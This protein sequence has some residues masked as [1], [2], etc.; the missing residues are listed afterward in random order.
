MVVVLGLDT[1]DASNVD[2]S[3]LGHSYFAEKHTVISD[4]FY[5]IGEGKAP[6]KRHSLEP[7]HSPKGQYWAFK[8]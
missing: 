6:D 5:L 1:V 7:K 4:L 8:A 2:T 3:F